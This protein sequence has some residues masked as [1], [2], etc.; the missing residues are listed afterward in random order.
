MLKNKEKE[1]N[2]KNE[3]SWKLNTKTV[4]MWLQSRN[5][6]KIV[7]AQLST[8]PNKKSGKGK[9]FNETLTSLILTVDVI[10]RYVYLTLVHVSIFSSH[11]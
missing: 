7:Q 1:K 11:V 9:K 10:R 8:N 6:V 3:F 4:R 5:V 2:Y